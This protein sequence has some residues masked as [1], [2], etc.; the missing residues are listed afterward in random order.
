MKSAAAAS[1][2]V[3]WWE[4]PDK[5]WQAICLSQAESEKEY[6]T[7]QSDHLLELWGKVGKN[8]PQTLLDWLENHLRTAHPVCADDFINPAKEVLRRLSAGEPGPVVVS[9]W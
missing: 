8:D 3:V 7:R 4:L 1:V 2:W 9:T 6:E 5:S